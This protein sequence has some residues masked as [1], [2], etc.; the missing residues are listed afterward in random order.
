VGQRVALDIIIATELLLSLFFLSPVSFS[1]Y[2]ITL[3]AILLTFEQA[4][5]KVIFGRLIKNARM[6]G[7]RN[8]EE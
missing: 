6:Q 4:V 2:L 1:F 3:A 5:E 7:A 8:P